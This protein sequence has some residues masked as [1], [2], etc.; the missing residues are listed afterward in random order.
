ML[1]R[2]SLVKRPHKLYR[3]HPKYLSYVFVAFQTWCTQ[4]FFSYNF[5]TFLIF[6]SIVELNGNERQRERENF[7]FA[8]R[9]ICISILLLLKNGT[10]FVWIKNLKCTQ[11]PSIMCCLHVF[12]CAP[13]VRGAIELL[14]WKNT[15]PRKKV[16]HHLSK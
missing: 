2:I 1:E 14:W 4:T 9:C 6:I 7:I 12:V 5:N 10:K 13:F 11:K 3:L 15:R 16:I 8:F